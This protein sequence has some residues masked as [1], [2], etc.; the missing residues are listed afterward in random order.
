LNLPPRTTTAQLLAHKEDNSFLSLN[1]YE[2]LCEINDDEEI[3]TY[4]ARSLN[5]LNMQNTTAINC[6][7]SDNSQTLANLK[8]L[9]NLNSINTQDQAGQ[10]A[11]ILAVQR[12]YLAS[13]RYLIKEG[14]DKGIRCHQDYSAASRAYTLQNFYCNDPIK[15]HLYTEIIA[16]FSDF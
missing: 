2:N 9:L 4:T 11:L 14:A 5:Q 1:C 7:G 15:Y 10:T 8:A 13:V 6:I 12:G 3:S 16:A